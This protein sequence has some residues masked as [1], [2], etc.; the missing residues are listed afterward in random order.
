MTAVELLKERG[1]KPAEIGVSSRGHMTF[2]IEKDGEVI[3]LFTIRAEHG[4]IPYVVHFAGKPGSGWALVNAL[5]SVLRR[6]G[7]TQAILNVPTEKKSLLAAAR[8][9]LHA[10]PYSEVN[11]TTFLIME[12]CHG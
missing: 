11:G 9:A 1:L 2:N 10:E 8:R 3:G 4:Q 5:K 6:V 12:V 7:A